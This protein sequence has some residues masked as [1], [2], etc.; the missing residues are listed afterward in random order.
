MCRH[1]CIIFEIEIETTGM[2]NITNDHRNVS[3]ARVMIRFDIATVSIRFN[4]PSLSL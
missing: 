4:S 1:S 2:E 3:I